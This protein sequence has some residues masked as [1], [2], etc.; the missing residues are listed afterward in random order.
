[1]GS[2]RGGT[3]DLDR[4]PLARRA[5]ASGLVRCDAAGR[6]HRHFRTAAGNAILDS[7]VASI[8]QP[9]PDAIH[10]V[11]E[12]AVT[13]TMGPSSRPDAGAGGGAGAWITTGGGQGG[14]AGTW[15]TM[16]GSAPGW[17]GWAVPRPSNLHVMGA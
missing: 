10:R 7:G 16:G 11:I 9:K 2:G 15:I 14:G 5:S 3:T 1:M 17:G 13:E 6:H 4:A 8:S 12:P